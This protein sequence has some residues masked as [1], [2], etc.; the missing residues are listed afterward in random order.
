MKKI[1]A[2]ILLL[3]ALFLAL[4]SGAQKTDPPFLHLLNAPWVDSVFNTL[5]PD[6]RIAQLILVA[7]WS[8]KDEAHRQEILGL[9]REQKIGGLVFFQGAPGRQANLINAYQR[10]SKVPLLIA[11]DAE[12]GVGM[13]LDSAIRYPYQMTLGAIQDNELIYDMGRAIAMQLK[14]TGV[15]VN[16]APVIDVNNNPNNPVISYRSFGEN[17][18]R[19]AAKGVAYM[20]GMQDQNLLTTAK[21]F[22]GHGDTD[23]DSHYSL[24]QIRHTR[25]RLDSIELFPFREL[26]RAGIGGIM[27]AHLN[28]PALDSTGLPSTLSKPIVTKLLKDE[29]GFD[30]LIVTDAM[31]MKGVTSGNDPGIVD[32]NAILA[33]ND[34]LEFT[35]DVPRAIAEI[36][37]AIRQ[38]KISQEEIDR[39]C[40]KMLA[41]KY[42]VGL[43]DY[44]PVASANVAKDINTP[45]AKLL[46]RRLMAAALTVLRNEHQLI[47]LRKLDTLRV[48]SVSF[49]A[50]GM[51]PFQKTLSLY[52]GVRHFFV[53]DQADAVSLDK[54]REE[55]KRYSVVVAGIHDAGMRPLNRVNYSNDVLNFINALAQENHSI[56]AVFRNPYVL[57]KLEKI[58]SADGLILAYE[59]NANAEELAAQLIGA[60]LLHGLQVE[61]VDDLAVQVALELAIGLIHRAAGWLSRAGAL[62]GGLRARALA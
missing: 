4:P 48:A 19:V 40:R 13:R 57:D 58:S 7:A 50:T 24:P 54:I 36:R 61:L 9:I 41:V 27:V 3:I 44:K 30:G 49:G 53:P 5:T 33:G 23:V 51:T 29:L 31:N 38:G 20:K 34:M 15:N 28:I 17:R 6:E 25:Q 32:K 39:R 43:H 8:N 1:P 16:F 26:I 46:N 10:H 11:M 2:Y 14:R 12:W 21:H 18:E 52:T 56:F 35:E 62:L 22:P 45:A 37:K 47:P 59:D 42:W 60:E 55:L